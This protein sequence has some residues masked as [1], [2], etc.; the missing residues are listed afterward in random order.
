MTMSAEFIR[1]GLA[2]SMGAAL[3]L[4]TR[5]P[6]LF[7]IELPAFFADGD[8]LAIYVRTVGSVSLVVTDLGEM[9]G[10]LLD[11]GRPS[12]MVDEVLARFAEAHGFALVDGEIRIEVAPDELFASMLALLQIETLADSLLGGF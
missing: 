12:E 5:A 3:N 8:A 4:R 7:Q 9:R 6:G 11:W 2:D 1:H 10:R